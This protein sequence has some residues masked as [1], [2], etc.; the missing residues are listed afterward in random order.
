MIKSFAD[1]HSIDPA[2]FADTGALDPIPGIDTKL[3]IDPSLLRDA[4]TPEI[5]KKL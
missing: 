1:L 4:K 2:V 5:E 3:F